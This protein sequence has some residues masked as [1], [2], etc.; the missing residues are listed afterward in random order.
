MGGRG[1]GGQNSGRLEAVHPAVLQ[2]QCAALRELNAFHF[3]GKGPVQYLFLAGWISVIVVTVLAM[4]AAFR[5]HTGWRRWVLVLLM[6][7]GLTPTL[8]VNW[9]TATVWVLEAAS[10][11]AGYVIPFFC[12]SLSHG[13]VW[14]YRD[15]RYVLL[16]FGSTHCFRLFDLALE[17]VAEATTAGIERG[18][19]RLIH[20]FTVAFATLGFHFPDSAEAGIHG[21]GVGQSELF[22]MTGKVITLEFVLPTVLAII[23]GVLFSIGA[24]YVVDLLI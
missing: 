2:H 1:R 21:A 17:I 12:P 15:W 13:P 11:S 7:L 16:C 8:A 23:L 4:I 22:A 24:V 14:L 9:N 10:N 18:S 20:T 5:R 19:S 6:P 3:F